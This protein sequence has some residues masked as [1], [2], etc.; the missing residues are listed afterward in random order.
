MYKGEPFKKF[1]LDILDER[2]QGND[3]NA[4]PW[5]LTIS[6]LP[7][8]A[9]CKGVNFQLDRLPPLRL[10][11]FGFKAIDLL[12]NVSGMYLSEED[13][14]QN[15]PLCSTKLQ[16]MSGIEMQPP[17]KTIR[18]YSNDKMVVSYTDDRPHSVPHL[19]TIVL[20]C[21]LNAVEE[22]KE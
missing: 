3:E 7:P 13:W 21:E 18:Y 16:I 15:L 22:D 19:Q 1:V 11:D 20:R 6:N 9:R 14:N 10:K 2:V 4:K 17:A 12:D 5:R 8:T